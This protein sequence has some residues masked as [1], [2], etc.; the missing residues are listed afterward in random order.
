MAGRF[1]DEDI[2]AVRDK[3][4]IDEVIGDYVTLRNAGSGSMKGLCPFH[5][6]KT[7][8]FNV[9]PSRGSFHCFG[10]QKGGDA[11]AFLQEIDGLTFVEALERLA[12]KAG[13]QLRR[14]DGD[15]RDE[16]PKG[17]PRQRLV[18]VNRVAQEYY[19]EQLTGAV[20]VEGRRFLQ[21]RGF[22]QATAEHFGMGFAPRDGE[23]LLK[24]LRG[25]GFTQDE[26]VGA[27]LVAVGRSAY[28]RFR[29]RL[30]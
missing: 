1:R 16:R 21:E 22:D 19:A 4:R 20:A 7:P 15:A 18:E 11:I 26:A 8:S 25:R 3:V 5:D 23:A 17:P 6:E 27:G 2:A 13:V 10:C 9:S 24:H 29:G 14:E 30:L 28:D 12:D